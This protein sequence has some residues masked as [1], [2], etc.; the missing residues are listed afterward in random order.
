MLTVDI[1]DLRRPEQKHDKVIA[2][3]EEGNEKNDNHCLLG[4]AEECSGYHRVWCVEL[5]DEESNE[6]DDTEDQRSEVVRAA[7]RVL[8]T[9]SDMPSEWIN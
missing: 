7:P 2:T 6:K 9:V 4:L 8:I 1:V 3:T 5:P